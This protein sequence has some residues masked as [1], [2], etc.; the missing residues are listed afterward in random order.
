MYLEIKYAI[1]LD[2]IQ[3]KKSKKYPLINPITIFDGNFHLII[4]NI[5]IKYKVW[6]LF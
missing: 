6:I 2:K 4:S 1:Q 3:I 5:C